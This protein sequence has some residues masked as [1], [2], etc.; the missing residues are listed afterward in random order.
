MKVEFD[1][2]FLVVGGIDILVCS[3]LLERGI[4]F[5]IDEVIIYEM[6]DSIEKFKHRAGRT[7]RAGRGGSVTVFVSRECTILREY[8][9][10][11]RENHQ[12]VIFRFYNVGCPN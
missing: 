3:S 12:V 7:G 8:R 2:S 6:P 9:R 5:A 1:L 10:L 11:L 4:D